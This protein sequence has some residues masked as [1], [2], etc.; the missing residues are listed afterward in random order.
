MEPFMFSLIMA[1][2]LVRYG[3]TDLVATVRG[4][5]SP[6]YRERQQRLVQQHERRMARLRAGPTIGQ[7][8][9]GRIARRIAE[10]RPPR[11]R[12]GQRP[13]RR[14]VGEWWEDSWNH[15]TESRHRHRD[16]KQADDLPRQRAYRATRNA[17]D[18]WR[19]SRTANAPAGGGT[20]PPT[21]TAGGGGVPPEDATE[22]TG[23]IR[24]VAE[25]LPLPPATHPEPDDPLDAELADDATAPETPNRPHTPIPEE[26]NTAAM[27]SDST[28]IT[29]PTPTGE[30]TNIS[31]ALDY[32]RGMQEQFTAAVAHTEAV[33]AQTQQMS[34]WS[35]QAATSAETALAGISAGEVTGEAVERL[36]AAHEQMTAAADCVQRAADALQLAQEQFVATAEGFNSA[37][38]AFQRQSTVAEAYAANPDAGS[39]AFNTYA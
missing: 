9:T 32:T 38:Q 22:R 29:G 36:H 19:H 24:V 15:A 18:R 33:T 11:D 14:F 17:F 30:I 37:H 10:P 28:P 1:W 31:T 23:P 27:P 35:A 2:A 16:R 39:K 7:A 34:D 6:R 3:V 21:D 12:T 4:T 8:V 25:R 20:V 13:F 5:E 26:R